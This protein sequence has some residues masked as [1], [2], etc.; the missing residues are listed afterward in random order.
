MPPGAC[1]ATLALQF[2]GATWRKQWGESSV[3]R[4]GALIAAVT[5]A[6]LV[7]GC[8]AIVDPLPA[9]ATPSLD[10]AADGFA[11]FVY[12]T[13]TTELDAQQLPVSQ[14]LMVVDGSGA[15]R[16]QT[17]VPM[18]AAL[19]GSGI[20]F[21]AGPV[22]GN[23][24]WGT[25]D[26]IT[27]AIHVASIGGGVESTIDLGSLPLRDAIFDRSGSSLLAVVGSFAQPQLARIGLEG[28]EPEIIGP[29]G[30]REQVGGAS[31][32]WGNSLVSTPDGTRI[33]DSICDV[34]GACSYAIVS[35]ADGATKQLEVELSGPIQSLGD[36]VMITVV[37]DGCVGMCTYQLIDLAT[38]EARPF[39]GDGG[40]WDP[41]IAKSESGEDVIV[42]TGLTIEEGVPF[43]M[44][45]R[46]IE[47]GGER[48][49]T[50]W[51][52][53]DLNYL[54]LDPWRQGVVGPPGTVVTAPNGSLFD[55][56]PS[57]VR[58][59]DGKVFPLAPVTIG[60]G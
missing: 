32:V 23:V 25:T 17:E 11:S 31:E 44:M 29:L 59:R 40:T 24:A 2:A 46:A 52:A 20:V 7:A 39:D 33:V 3:R 43:P 51:E 16:W 60:P 21:T 8:A 56:A 1:R 22:A 34:S 26:G 19:P 13:S 54:M 15:T 38:G 10:P 49:V 45:V 35:L 53:G 6:A 42:F 55:G 5:V 37:P 36:T 9:P 48:L 27:E 18:D 57:I 50:E 47:T 4:P 58:L 28:G 30:A 14:T 12:R 41:K